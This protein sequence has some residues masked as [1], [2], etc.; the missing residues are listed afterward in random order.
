V[1]VDKTGKVIKA[2][3]TQKGS[4]NTDSEL[5]EI[6]RKAALQFKFTLSEIEEQCGTITVDFKVRG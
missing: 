2:V 3:Y 6:A 5:K 1:C 4:T